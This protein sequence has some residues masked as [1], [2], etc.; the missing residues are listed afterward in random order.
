MKLHEFQAKQILNVFNIP[1]PRG[2]VAQT[3]DDAINAAKSVSEMGW[4]VKSQIHAGGRGKGKIYHKDNRENLVLDGG[5]KLAKSLDEVRNFAS[6]IL[7]NILV[8]KQSGPDGKTVKNVLIEEMVKIQKDPARPGRDSENSGFRDSEMYLAITVDRSKNQ[9]VLMASAEGGMDIE[10]VAEKNPDAILKEWFLPD[11]G[12]KEYQAR[13]IVYKLGLRTKKSI[14]EMVKLL[15]NL[16][17]TAV[18]IDAS[19]I[20]INPCVITQEQE[21]V[22]LDA[23]ITIEDNA[24]FKHPDLLKMRDLD[25]ENQVEVEA[26]NAGLSFISLDGDIGCLVNGAGLAMATMDIIKLYGGEKHAPANFLDVGGGANQEQVKKAFSIILQDPKVKGILVNIFGGIMR[27]D[28]LAQGIVAAAK[29]I[30]VNV[31][32]VVRLEGNK[33]EEGRLILDA[34]GLNIIPA[35]SMADAAQKIVDAVK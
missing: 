31:P 35:E 14:S 4:V 19:L 30:G 7:G 13:N 22:A 1:V 3:V 34:S 28:I 23:K 32:L 24:L 15:V 16:A 5:V 27:G 20:E 12:L 6:L 18:E 8:T 33:S 9:L 11:A 10:E 26:D 17:K 29:E 25:E 2:T 21:V